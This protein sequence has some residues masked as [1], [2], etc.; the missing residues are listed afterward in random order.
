M[1]KKKKAK[2]VNCSACR[3]I[4]QENLTNPLLGAPVCSTCHYNYNS[5][6]FTIEGKNEIYCRWCGEGEGEIILCDSCPKSFCSRC[7]RNIFGEAEVQRIINLPDRWNCFMCSPESLMDLIKKNGWDQYDDSNDVFQRKRSLEPSRPGLISYDI[8]RGRERIEIPVINTVDGTPPPLD[9]VYVSKPVAG[10]HA[11]IC[12]DPAFLTCCDC[13]DNCR[14]ATK[15]QCIK[16]SRGLCY[17]LNGQL[18]RDKGTG[19]YECNDLCRCHKNKCKNRVVSRGPNQ[20]LEVFRCSNGKGWGVRC[21]DEIPA[22]TYSG[23]RC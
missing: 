7:I 15:C 17:D 19:I 10:Q 13:T 9:F 6:D 2:Q 22:G 5:G 8:S 12:N 11:V 4:T 20:R 1:S 23:G 14:D 18:L 3:Q 16:N 21:R